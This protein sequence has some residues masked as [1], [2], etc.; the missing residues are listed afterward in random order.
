MRSGP[1]SFAQESFWTLAQLGSAEDPAFHVP[2][3]L[4]LSGPLDVDALRRAISTVVERH[5][6]LRTNFELSDGSPTQIVRPA[7]CVPLPELDLST[8]PA[9]DRDRAARE[10]LVR[11]SRRTFDLQRGPLLRAVLIRL[12]QTEHLLL[13]TTHHIAS[14]GW[15]RGILFGE[16]LA[17]YDA[18]SL[19]RAPALPSLPYQYLDFATWQRQ[20]LPGASFARDLDYWR[21]APARLNPSNQVPIR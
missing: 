3:T 21:A 7:A 9:E 4:R 11:E 14:D 16:L 5:E 15:S 20:A 10:Q 19:G 17:G 12:D 6:V 18:F 1:L 2:R 8:L 13:L